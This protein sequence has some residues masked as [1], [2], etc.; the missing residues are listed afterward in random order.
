MRLL[1]RSIVTILE[2]QADSGAYV[3]SPDFE[4][5]RYCWLRDG[6]FTAHAMDRVG[7]HQ[8]ARAFFRWVDRTIRAHARKVEAV[9]RKREEGLPIGEGDWLHTRYTLE[10]TEAQAEWWNFQLDGYGTWLWA[11]REHIESFG[12]ISFLAEVASSVG[13]TVRYL[14]ALWNHPSYD[15][16]EENAEYLHP[17]SLAAVFGGL[18]SAE[19]LARL[20]GISSLAPE[21]GLAEQLRV[22]VL[23]HGVHNGYVVKSFPPPC[24]PP[25]SVDDIATSVD[26]SLLGLATPFRLLASDDQL[27]RKTV[28]LIE[29]DLHLAGGVHRYKTD[30]YYGGGEWILLTAWL[31]WYYAE[32]GE[33]A[34]AAELLRWVEAQADAD[35]LLPEQVTGRLLAPAYHAK[36]V[37]KWGPVAKPLL[38]SHAMYLI[39]RSILETNGT[40]IR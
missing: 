4:V 40:C 25:V 28:A 8:S 23:D 2:N 34:R 32:L 26:A 24:G 16:W 13:L 12:D 11:L 38:W 35:G 33:T 5:Y 27:M 21:T 22:F 7:E 14:A 37:A 10:G 9:L 6:S 17:Y 1:R 15:C 29:R 19:A 3:A 36:W 31:G 18:R 39:L 20:S 30:T